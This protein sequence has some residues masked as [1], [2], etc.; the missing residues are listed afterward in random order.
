MIRISVIFYFIAFLVIAFSE[1]ALASS[2]S[3][4][5]DSAYSA[6]FVAEEAAKC[7]DQL[8]AFYH[9]DYLALIETNRWLELHSGNLDRDQLIKLG[10]LIESE[11]PVYRTNDRN[12]FIVDQV[13]PF[14]RL[15]LPSIK[16]GLYEPTRP[17]DPNE[18]RG[19]L[20]FLPGIGAK[21]SHAGRILDITGTF[22]GH[23]S[24]NRGGGEKSADPFEALAE[25]GKKFRLASYAFD[26]TMNGMGE[27]M[28]FVFA[29]EP[30]VIEVLRH[31][32]LILGILN[33]K[34]KNVFMAGRSQGGLAAIAYATKYS[35]VKGVVAVNPSS[36]I[37]DVVVA[38]LRVH[39]NGGKVFEYKPLLHHRAWGAYQY[40]TGS[41]QTLERKSKV[42]T[43]I[44][45][46]VLDQSYSD[47]QMPRSV[48]LNQMEGF[49]AGMPQSRSIAHFNYSHDLWVRRDNPHYE[50]VATDMG[51]FFA[52]ALR[53]GN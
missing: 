31:V 20:I 52:Q 38:S 18:H 3:G 41:F 49:V 1:R 37:P 34:L 15:Y 51:E 42:P 24:K 16:S 5:E 44:Y 25:G 28:P 27:N 12:E 43:R 53:S 7:G 29:S 22:H 48:Y 46:S 35:D 30:G 17:V 19:I 11:E 6:Q 13:L 4:Y 36:T 10:Y 2:E 21:T 9:P 8:Q 45:I 47:E 40:F 23:R 32:R 39:D 14:R 33:P 26:L 50:A